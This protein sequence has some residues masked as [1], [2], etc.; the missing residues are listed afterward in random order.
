MKLK[1]KVKEICSYLFYIALGIIFA[2]VLKGVL[3]RSTYKVSGSSMFPTYQEG[4]KVN[5]VHYKKGT[6]I[7]RYSV[8]VVNYKFPY[9]KIIKRIVAFP[10]ETVYIDEFGNLYVNGVE[11]EEELEYTHGN[12]QFAGVA[13]TEIQLG[14]DEYFLIGD[15]TEVSLDSRTFGPIKEKQIVAIVK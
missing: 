10:K 8:A 15:N 4:E 14:E 3:P 11:M 9:A 13:S 2:L 6:P 12:I 5:A 1:D 7:E